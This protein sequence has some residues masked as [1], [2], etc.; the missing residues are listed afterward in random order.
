MRIHL[1][2]LCF[3]LLAFL[4]GCASTST[5]MV[6]EDG[7]VINCGAWGF[8][9]IGAPVALISTQECIKKYRAAGYHEAGSLQSPGNTQAFAQLPGTGI[10]LT[11]KDGAFKIDLPAGWVQATPPSQAYQFYAKNP[12]LDAGLLVVLCY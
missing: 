9:I 10:T 11:A 8:G 2:S 3:A 4:G 5:Q 7:Q 12:T 1:Q 6:N